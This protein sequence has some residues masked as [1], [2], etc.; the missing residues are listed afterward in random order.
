MFLGILVEMILSRIRNI[1]LFLERKVTL[2]LFFCIDNMWDVKTLSDQMLELMMCYHP[3]SCFHKHLHMFSSEGCIITSV[4]NESKCPCGAPRL[5]PADVCRHWA[6]LSLCCVWSEDIF[7]DASCWW[8]LVLVGD[9]VIRCSY[10]TP[11]SRESNT[12]S[13]KK[14]T[15][16]L[17]V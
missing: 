12:F 2:L 13:I 4:M 11:K 14:I 5:I 17:R 16:F 9:V 6:A 1:K 8:T 7:C 10:F 3:L 15:T